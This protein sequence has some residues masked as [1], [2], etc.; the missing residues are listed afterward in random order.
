MIYYKLGQN[1]I[2]SLFLFYDLSLPGDKLLYNKS[3]CTVAN[4]PKVV[5]KAFYR[6]RNMARELPWTRYPGKASS[7]LATRNSALSTL[8]SYTYKDKVLFRCARRLLA[9]PRSVVWVSCNLPAIFLSLASKLI[10]LLFSKC[11]PYNTVLNH[12]LC[13]SFVV[14]HL[15]SLYNEWQL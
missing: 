3:F 6:T 12:L 7:R 11:W 15:K 5:E 8:P 4:I 14:P 10:C 9:L 13:E 1:R 2:E